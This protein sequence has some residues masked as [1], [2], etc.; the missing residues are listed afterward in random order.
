MYIFTFGPKIWKTGMCGKLG[1]VENW[2]YSWKTVFFNVNFYLNTSID[3]L[4]HPLIFRYNYSVM[5]ILNKK[6]TNATETMFANLQ[7]P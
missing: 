2:D 1:C 7:P 5:N 6:Y 4:I 3:I